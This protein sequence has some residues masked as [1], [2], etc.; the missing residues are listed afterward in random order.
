MWCGPSTSA[1]RGRGTPSPT[2]PP[3]HQWGCTGSGP[4]AQRKGT[5]PRN[6]ASRAS[7]GMPAATTHDHETWPGPRISCNAGHVSNKTTNTAECQNP[8]STRPAH[9]TLLAPLRSSSNPAFH[10]PFYPPARRRERGPAT[11]RGGPAQSA[12]ADYQAMAHSHSW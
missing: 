6:G 4:P 2:L 8:A 12:H 7:V 10:S 3:E 5:V 1:A 9:A 11:H